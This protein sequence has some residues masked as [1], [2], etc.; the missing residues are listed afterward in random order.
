MVVYELKRDLNHYRQ[1][2]NWELVAG[3][4][5]H[6]SQLTD[7]FRGPESVADIWIPP[8]VVYLD[9]GLIEGDF[10]AFGSFLVFTE[11]ARTSLNDMLEPNGE[12]LPL[13]CHMRTLVA[14]KV[15]RFIDALD[16]ENSKI[17]WFPQ[18]KKDAGKPKLIERIR[19]YCFHVEKLV[20]ATIFRIPQLP[21]HHV[22]VT[23]TFVRR[24]EEH[25]LTGFLFNQIWPP[26]GDADVRRK[27]LEK[28]RR[29]A[30]H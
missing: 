1:L 3:E 5:L 28:H 17:E 8:R 21:L 12:F 23:D 11:R 15:L 22:F 25:K 18:L 6:E 7:H 19:Q 20:D 13:K 24:V 30:P 4:K 2:T 26:I 14:F 29:K 27:F 9:E 16:L 10:P